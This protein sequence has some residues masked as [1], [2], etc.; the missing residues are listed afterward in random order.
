MTTQ[1]DAALESERGVRITRTFAF[2]R[3]VVFAAWSSSEHVKRWFCPNGF[4][5]PEARVEM[6]PGGPFEFC[7]R[8]PDGAEHWSR[9]RF[10]AVEPGER[11]VIEMD[12]QGPSGAVA[13]TALTTAT[14]EP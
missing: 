13:F 12:V 7:M 4:T 3:A 10:V 1:S 5:V 2:P 8:A 11:L 14:F 6:R 9:G